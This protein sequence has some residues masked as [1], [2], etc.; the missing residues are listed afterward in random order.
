MQ[1]I[2]PKTI[3]FGSANITN[4][5]GATKPLTGPGQDILKKNHFNIDYNQSGLSDA[6]EFKHGQGEGVII[7][8][9][10]D[11]FEGG[12]CKGRR[13]GKGIL[14]FLEGLKIKKARS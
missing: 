14:T 10:G 1:A 11:R 12:Y 7:F 6:C 13:L 4:N 5:I 2:E 9:N 8:K 3:F